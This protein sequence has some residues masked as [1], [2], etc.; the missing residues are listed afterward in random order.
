MNK[1]KLL[2][3]L[4]IVKPG[5]ASQEMIEQST[6]FA[7]VGN[8]VVTYNDEI[9]ISHPIEGMDITGAVKAKELYKLL[10]KI[11]KEEIEITVTETELR[12][13]AGKARAGLTFQQEITLP[14]EEIEK[15]GEWKLLPDGFLEALKFT[16]FTCSQDMSKP[17]LTCINVRKDGL[18]E[19]SDNYRITR[20]QVKE[21]PVPT[22]LLPATSA[23]E[24]VKYEITEIAQGQGW[25]HFRTSDGTIFSCRVFEENFPDTEPLIEVKGTEITLPDSMNEALSRASIFSRETYTDTEFVQITL[26][27]NKLTVHG[28]NDTGWYD[29]MLRVRYKGEVLSF[30]I[31]PSFLSKILASTNNCLLGDRV[32]KFQGE[33]WLHIIALVERV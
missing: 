33:N 17:V 10:A 25:I 31:N 29:E 21:M 12:L 24:L 23:R 11:D 4:E 3:A 13:T 14:L 30:F 28:K 19:S 1:Q 27:R 16:Q 5:L 15:Q 7:F 20:Y 6:S 18:I 32:I 9:S 2:K 8:R 22:F 26:E